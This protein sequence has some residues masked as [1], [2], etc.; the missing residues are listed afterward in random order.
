MSLSSSTRKD[1]NLLFLFLYL[2]LTLNVSTNPFISGNIKTSDLVTSSKYPIK[3][4]R[5]VLSFH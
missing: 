1:I 4:L 2:P 3:Y 5:I